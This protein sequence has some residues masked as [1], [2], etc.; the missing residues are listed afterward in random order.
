M[1]T[2]S[3]ETFMYL[4]PDSTHPPACLSGFI[5]GEFLR[6]IRNSSNA[7]DAQERSNL[8]SDK[9]INRGYKPKL[10]NDIRKTVSHEK[11][12]DY[13]KQK[14]IKNDKYPLVFIT[15]YTGHLQSKT[16]KTALTKHWGIIQ[17]NARLNQIF[18]T[19]PLIAFKRANNI[20]D[21]LVK[22]KLPPDEDLKILI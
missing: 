20:Q 18:P 22:A 11:R 8:F 10:I 15:E 5:K 3:C 13:L 16:L 21:K 9:L 14:P 7:K 12:P 4:H 19:P 1:Y 17:K 6:I 2:K